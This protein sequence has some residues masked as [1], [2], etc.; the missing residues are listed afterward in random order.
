MIND[1]L[2]FSKIEA[3][4]LEL[5]AAP[6]S[7]RAVLEEVTAVRTD[8]EIAGCQAFKVRPDERGEGERNDAPPK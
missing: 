8:K 7:L 6:F 4:Q 3:E 2:D 1:I 5:E